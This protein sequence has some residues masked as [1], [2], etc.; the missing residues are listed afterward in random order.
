VA[1][2]VTDDLHFNTKTGD[3]IWNGDAMQMGIVTVKDVQ[4]NLGLALTQSGVV[5]QQF[6]G[7]NNALLN[8][9]SRSVVRNEA[10][11]TTSYELSLPLAALGLE[12]GAEFGFNI[13]FLDDDDGKGMRYGIPLASG[14]LGRDARTPP[15]AKVYPR[16]VL[17]K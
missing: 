3:Q 16:F 11:H 10:A 7:A 1:A 13:A 17:T 15:P 2:K 6:S 4:W 8:V 9:A 5:L 12:P 14:L